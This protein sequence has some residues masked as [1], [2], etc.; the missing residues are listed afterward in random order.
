MTE[1]RRDLEDG[2]CSGRTGELQTKGPVGEE[3]NWGKDEA[4]GE[5]V[6]R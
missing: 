1:I 4:R 5:V 2:R 6:R 3:A